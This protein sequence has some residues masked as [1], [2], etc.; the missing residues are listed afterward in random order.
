MS[1]YSPTSTFNI[2]EDFYEFFLKS[3]CPSSNTHLY[4]GQVT[5]KVIFFLRARDIIGT[6]EKLSAF[7]L[8]G[9][10]YCKKILMTIAAYLDLVIAGK[11][12]KSAPSP[13]THKYF[14]F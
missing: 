11:T 7:L 10:F 8:F 1:I 5:V 6:Q 3:S 9:G 14:R 13:K 12:A 4:G 2:I